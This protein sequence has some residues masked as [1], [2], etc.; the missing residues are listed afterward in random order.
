MT[1]EE[2]LK[3]ALEI[4]PKRR[5]EGKVMCGSG[6]VEVRFIRTNKL[7]GSGFLRY[8]VGFRFSHICNSN[9][10]IKTVGCGVSW[11]E[12]FENS[13]KMNAPKERP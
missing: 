1:N 4:W 8:K 11:E 7:N 13:E 6:Y 5:S 9:W 3:K 12:A 2:A 10:D